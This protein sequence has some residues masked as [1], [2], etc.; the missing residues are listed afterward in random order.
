MSSN[1]LRLKKVLPLDGSAWIEAYKPLSNW[2][3]EKWLAFQNIADGSLQEGLLA[4]YEFQKEYLLFDDSLQKEQLSWLKESAQW[5]MHSMG[6]WAAWNT[7]F[8]KTPAW[9]TSIKSHLL[10]EYGPR[11]LPVSPPHYDAIAQVQDKLDRFWNRVQSK[12]RQSGEPFRRSVANSRGVWQTYNTFRQEM[13]TGKLLDHDARV[14]WN[15]FKRLA[16]APAA[17]KETLTPLYAAWLQQPTK[18]LSGCETMEDWIATLDGN[19][20][21]A[22]LL[23]MPRF[24]EERDY[25]IWSVPSSWAQVDP[26]VSYRQVV[27]LS[28]ACERYLGKKDYAE[29]PEPVLTWIHNACIRYADS[30]SLNEKMSVHDLF[31]ETTFARGVSYFERSSSISVARESKVQ[32]LMIDWLSEHREAFIGLHQSLMAMGFDFEENITTTWGSTR[33]GYTSA[34]A[35]AELVHYKVLLDHLHNTMRHTENEP[36]DVG[37]LFDT[38]DNSMLGI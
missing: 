27:Y 8:E 18:G 19:Q 22:S 13:K 17:W 28:D 36:L 23:P 31:I 1:T 25:Y 32:H 4:L 38:D 15:D 5:D 3:P 6:T 7:L 11:L 14:R 30:W 29:Y 9:S 20:L 33:R 2:S 34:S 16:D 12:V 21:N 37:H 10:E 35:R 26:A 24:S